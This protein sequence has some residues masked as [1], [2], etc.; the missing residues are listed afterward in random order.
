VKSRSTRSGG[1]VAVVEPWWGAPDDVRT[2]V[3]RAIAEP[4]ELTA[5]ERRW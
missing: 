3:Q 5:F 2:A 4:G 1:L